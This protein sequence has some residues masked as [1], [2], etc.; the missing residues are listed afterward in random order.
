CTYA[1]PDQQQAAYR[2]V[3]EFWDGGRTL[4][5]H[6]Q[7]LSTSPQH[8]RARWCVGCIDDQVVV[9]L[10]CY[11]VQLSWQGEQI[12]TILIGAVYTLPAYRGR[13]YAPRLLAWVEEQERQRGAGA[14]GLFSDIDP[15]YYER[16]GYERCD[17]WE[18]KISV[19]AALETEATRWT[20]RPID[21]HQQLP[22]LRQWYEASQRNLSV[23]LVRDDAYWQYMLNKSAADCFFELVDTQ[24]ESH[25]YV[26]LQAKADSW[27]IRDWG[28]AQPGTASLED[29]LVAIVQQASQQG[30]TAIGGWL[31]LLEGFSEMVDCES[32][33]QEITM[34]KSLDPDRQ[35]APE[36]VQ[37]AAYLREIDHI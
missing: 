6:L 15:D 21:P 2:N 37:A 30:I 12:T 36:I 1:N 35:V 25:G 16:F 33:L 7:W 8:N 11:P 14:S 24:D 5:E 9:S 31:P 4:E 32:R 18:L 10:G 13:G 3:H 17:S 34:F 23:W 19:K 29:M 27:V 20:L 26:R 22:R 28:L